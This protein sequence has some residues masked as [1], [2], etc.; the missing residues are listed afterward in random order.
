MS[1]CLKH[2]LID[3]V[4]HQCLIYTIDM[5]GV[6]GSYFI[7]DGHAACSIV[8]GAPRVDVLD[9]ADHLS[10][11]ARNAKHVWWIRLLDALLCWLLTFN[12][13]IVVFVCCWFGVNDVAVLLVVVVLAV[14]CCLH[15]CSH[16]K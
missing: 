9:E 7:G 11:V 6:G 1:L 16:L 13:Y 4:T 5:V 15:G 3:H 12:C 10:A 14:M 2:R 8:V